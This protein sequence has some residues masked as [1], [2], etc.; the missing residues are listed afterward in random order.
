MNPKLDE[1][2]ARIRELQVELEADL[3]QKR[4]E[5]RDHLENRRV[6]EQA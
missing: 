4:E 3:A 5:L 6:R 2:M 1:L